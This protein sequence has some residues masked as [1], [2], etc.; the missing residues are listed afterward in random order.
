MKIRVTSFIP[1]RVQHG[2]SFT[3]YI[4]PEFSVFWLG[5]LQVVYLSWLFF[6]ISFKFKK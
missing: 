3:F 1:M 6:E 5:G 2:V 4:L